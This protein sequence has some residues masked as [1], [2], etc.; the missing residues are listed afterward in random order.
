MSVGLFY[1]PKY[2]VLSEN[3]YQ[4]KLA[5]ISTHKKAYELIDSETKVLDL[6][7]ADGYLSKELEIKKD[8][9]Y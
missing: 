8:V 6:G 4:D 9:K 7:C 2:E 3:K 1:D 5:F